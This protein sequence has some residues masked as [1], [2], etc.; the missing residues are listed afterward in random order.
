MLCAVLLCLAA[1]STHMTARAV[2]ALLMLRVRAAACCLG[3]ASGS[4][5]NAP[6]SCT[7]G[8]P[9]T[10]DTRHFQCLSVV[11]LCLKVAAATA[12]AAVVYL[13]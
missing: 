13:Q 2:P 12:P 3:L 5:H 10:R 7:G 4:H 6:T 8:A 1:V 11:T 9:L